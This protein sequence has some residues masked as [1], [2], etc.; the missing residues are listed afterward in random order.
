ME[1]EIVTFE[2]KDLS[3]GVRSVVTC[4]VMKCV[5][6]LGK[7]VTNKALADFL[8]AKGVDGIIVEA[9]FTLYPK[10]RHPRVL[11]LEFFGR[12]THN[13]MLVIKDVIALRN[14]IRIDGDYV[15]LSAL[16]EFGPK[17]VQ[18]IE[19]KTKSTT[20]EGHPISVLI[21]QVDGDDAHLLDTTV[22]Q[23]VDIAM[24]YEGV[25]AFV[26][27]DEKEAEIFWEDR[28]RLSAIAKPYALLI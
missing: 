23:I 24:P 5:T 20:Y 27:K 10:L 18:A 2:V 15:K 1:E 4:V 19:Y 11:V 17:Y 14:Q 22:Q 7:D 28:H 25:D 8:G 21:I 16:E 6:G 3:G 26:A 12:S 9:S 13:A